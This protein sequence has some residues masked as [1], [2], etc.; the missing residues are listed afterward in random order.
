MISVSD[1][2]DQDLSMYYNDIAHAQD[3]EVNFVRTNK[4]RRITCETVALEKEFVLDE[5]YVKKLK[6]Q[7]GC[8]I[9]RSHDARQLDFVAMD[10]TKTV[11]AIEHFFGMKEIRAATDVLKQ[12]AVLCTR[13]CARFLVAED[14][15]KNS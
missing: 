1:L 6:A 11:H 4:R 8:E 5:T 12:Y 7:I 13:C 9:C 10:K 15:E 14:G 3:T 2:L